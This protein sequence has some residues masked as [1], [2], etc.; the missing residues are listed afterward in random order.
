MRQHLKAA[1]GRRRPSAWSARAARFAV[2]EIDEPPASLA[3]GTVQAFVDDFIARGAAAQVDYVHGDD[4]LERLAQQPGHVGA[5]PGHRGQERTAASVWCSTARCRAR[6]SRWAKPTRSAS[7]S[8]RAASARPRRARNAA[9]ATKGLAAPTQ[10]SA[11]WIRCRNWRWALRS[12]WPSWAGA[13][14]SWKAAMWGGMAGTLPDLDVLLDHGDP[15]PQHGAAP[16]RDPRAVL[17]DAVLAAPCGGRRTAARRM[18]PMAALVAGALAGAGDAPA[19]GRDDGL[20]HATGAALQ[21]P[22]LRCRQHVDHRP[23]VHTAAAGRRRL[24]AGLRGSAAGLRANVLGLRSAPPTWA[25]A[26][27][28]SSRCSAWRTRIAAG[29]GHPGRSAC[30]SCRRYFNS[31]LWRVVAV[32]GA[33]YH[34]GFHSL[35]DAEPAHRLR[36]LRSR[37]APWPRAGAGHRRRAAH[38]RLQQGLLQAAGRGRPRAGQRPAHGPGAGL[39]S[40][41]SRWRSG[42][43]RHCRWTSPMQAGA[44]PTCNAPCPGCGIACGATRCRRRAERR[45]LTPPSG[46]SAAASPGASSTA[47]RRRRWPGR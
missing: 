15:D 17:A 19:A 47:R 22:P 32:D 39:R 41:A 29:A 18:G 28:R 40:S 4:V 25:G 37:H 24:G 14:P 3:V 13:R 12:A 20:R 38:R 9:G 16:R 1:R 5:A 46:R 21:Q 43:A 35:L 45:R 26:W 7:T 2:V 11:P 23:A 30:W 31:L 10:N 44:G 33:H 36:P 27:W 34:E 6:P 42:T 8:R